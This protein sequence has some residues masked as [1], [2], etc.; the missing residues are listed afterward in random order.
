[1]IAAWWKEGGVLMMGYELYRLL[2]NK[3]QKKKKRRKNAGP[4]VVDIDE[5]DRD[6][7]LLEGDFF[8]RKEKRRCLG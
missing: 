5:E 2:A 8:K 4:E 3:T 7:Q 6:K 1:M